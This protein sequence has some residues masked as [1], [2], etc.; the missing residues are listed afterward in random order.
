VLH[1]GVL[2]NS[3]GN[4][5]LRTLTVAGPSFDNTGGKLTVLRDLMARTDVFVN[6]KG[7]LLIGASF[8]GR[9]SSFSNL[10]G[11]LQAGSLA[12]DVQR[13][14]DN[15]GGT[16]RHLGSTTAAINVGGE[17]ALDRGTLESAS[18]LRLS[19]G[20]ISGNASTVNVIGDLTL[21]AGAASTAKGTWLVAGNASLRTGA[22]DNAGGKIAT[23]GTLSVESA[24]L[25]GCLDHDW[26]SPR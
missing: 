24:A 4:A 3:G 2:D 12:L 1:A 17:L 16:L 11:V 21:D 13:S 18:N 19:A 8:D 23:G 25:S 7:S 22:L 10:L 5:Y 9:F 6:D 14:I 26:W 20:F 15:R